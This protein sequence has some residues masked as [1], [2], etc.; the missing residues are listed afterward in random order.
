MKGGWGETSGFSSA[1]TSL[2]PSEWI[3]DSILIPYSPSLSPS[4]PS[5]SFQPAEYPYRSPQLRPLFLLQK[6]KE[7]TPSSLLPAAGQAFPRVRVA[8]N[9]RSNWSSHATARRSTH[10]LLGPLLPS[11]PSVRKAVSGLSPRRNTS[12]S[13]SAWGPWQGVSRAGK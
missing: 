7:A 6:L 3:C 9:S 1:F 11:S 10:V 5:P 8:Q 4:Q 12:P 13:G 2:S